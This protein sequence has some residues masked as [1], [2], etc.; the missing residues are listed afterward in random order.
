MIPIVLASVLIAT[1]G[2]GKPPIEPL[3]SH[4]VNG[5]DTS[6][7]ERDSKWRHTC[8]GALVSANWVMSFLSYRVFVGKHNLVEEEADSQDILPEK[9]IV[10]EKSN[11][12]F[13]AFSN[14]IAMIKLSQHVPV[15][16]H[17]RLGCIPAAGTLLPNLYPCYITG[18]GR[19]Y[20]KFFIVFDENPMVVILTRTFAAGAGGGG[21]CGNSGGTLNC[22]NSE[23]V[24]EVHG[25][26]SFVS[27]LGCNFV[28]K[29]TVFTRV[30][31]FNGWIDK[32]NRTEHRQKI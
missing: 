25:I 31:A 32:V 10:H 19:L 15:N 24:W 9:I 29:P 26:A 30:F 28:K 4:V 6:L 3:A 16:D 12:I 7:D 8:G 22:K 17:V 11:P 21:G 13:V 5:E 23:G 2:C 20:S 27:S 1:L 18:W 14:D